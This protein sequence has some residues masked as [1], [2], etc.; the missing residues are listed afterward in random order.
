[1]GFPGF[2]LPRIPSQSS[3]LRRP[4]ACQGTFLNTDFTSLPRSLHVPT[5]PPPPSASQTMNKRGCLRTAEK[6]SSAKQRGDTSWRQLPT[7]A[8]GRLLCCPESLEE[9][10]EAVHHFI[11]AVKI[12]LNKEFKVQD[13]CLFNGHS[14]VLNVLIA[15]LNH[16]YYYARNAPNYQLK[17]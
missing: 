17:I 4:E 9:R 7:T 10:Q 5:V 13:L 1:M 6:S 3:R 8:T 12:M 11:H 14:T 16:N 2:P 15:S